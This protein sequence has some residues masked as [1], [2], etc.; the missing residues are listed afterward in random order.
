MSLKIFKKGSMFYIIDTETDVIAQGHAKNVL[1]CQLIEDEPI[2]QFKN[3]HNFSPISKVDITSAVGEDGE[4]PYTLE[5]FVNFIEGSTG[6]DNPSEP[7]PITIS[8]TLGEGGDEYID[9]P[10]VEILT[11]LI[12]EE[13]GD[14]D[15]GSSPIEVISFLEGLD[16]TD[17]SA[18][19]TAVG[20]EFSEYTD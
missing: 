2:F 19:I 4:T 13:A 9:V 7:T 1:A 3:L 6:S 15:A 11:F 14:L 16:Q 5:Q 20:T 18:L 17:D 12:V 8:F 10:F